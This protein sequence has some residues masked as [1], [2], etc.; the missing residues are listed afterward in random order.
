MQTL[1]QD[2]RYGLR[3]FTRSL[4]FTLV[5]VLSLALGI[6][7]N[8]AIF[9]LADTVLLRYLPVR[10]PEKLVILAR[11]SPRGLRTNFS[12]PIYEDFR[13]KQDVFSGVLARNV[14]P[15]NMEASSGTER[16]S[17]ELVS[18]NY[19][20]VLGVEALLGRA[21]T[22]EDDLRPGA[23]PVAVFS[24]GFWQRRFGGDP[25]VM[26]HTI[27]LNGHPFTVVGVSPPGFAGVEI[28]F[29]PEIRVPMMMQNDLMP[30]WTRMRER[31]TSWLEVMARLKPGLSRAQA[32]AAVGTLYQG[33]L[34]LELQGAGP[35]PPDL[36]HRFLEQRLRLLPGGRG[37]SDV[38]EELSTPL[39]ALMGVVGF[40]LLIAC[41]NVANLLLA[42]AAGRRRE[43]AIRLAVGASRGRLVRQLLT[44]SIL[45][46]CGGGVL[47]LLL[48]SY[49]NTFLLRF[50]PQTDPPVT[51]NLAP[52]WRI[53][54]FTLLVSLLTGVL[55]GLGPGMQATRTDI[56]PALKDEAGALGAGRAR[57][58]LRKA[59]L[60][61][62]VALSLVL[63]IGAGLLVRSLQKLRDLDVG[64]L[65][66]NVLLLSLDPGLSGYNAQRAKAFYEGLLERVR[67]LP[68]VRAAS[69]ASVN[70]LTGGGRRS[71]YEV[72]GYQ[73]RPGEDMALNEN[74]L[75]P[76][77]FETLGIPVLLGRDFRP[78]DDAGS[79]K[80][81]IVN[82][83]MARY[84]FKDENP[85]GKRIGIGNNRRWDIEIIGV[86][87]NAKYRRLREDTWRTVYL[88][89]GQSSEQGLTL[90]LRAIGEPK[91]TAAAVR[92]E[93]QALDS[94]LPVFGVR[95]MA[96]QL[97]SALAPERLV[98]ALSS[99]FGLLALLL[100]AVGLYGVMAYSVARR[101]RE[102][103]IRMALGA[104]RSDVLWM[105]LRETLALTGLGV[106][107]GIP[108][109]F[110]LTRLVSTLLYQVR[111]TDVATTAGATV[112]LAA[113]ALLAGYLPARRAARVDPIV[114]LRYE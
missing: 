44:E 14:I 53:L 96:E 25:S 107:A 20:S 3:Q 12:Y 62:Q 88:P 1:L 21:L 41:A 2:L 29:A 38:R 19:F 51:F 28:G 108:A 75:S 66:E 39:L 10:R 83:Q 37:F 94:S 102:I 98:A 24:Y 8:T 60:A 100:A 79:P 46:A 13:D 26:G 76:G 110:A 84:F 82:E 57:F 74:I 92:Q 7:A 56:S 97:D 101:T 32:E 27:R 61:G 55:F 72:Q 16:V 48:A 85:I 99:L 63:L 105:V 9:T 112:F 86:V 68:G 111:P 103:G 17:G 43:I 45:L 30:G 65:R 81:A 67:T 70:L 114:A 5:A 33:L 77:Y 4:A 50:I 47:G 95:T 18:G 89:L 52:D 91:N 87:K 35:V 11:V 23:H 109:A 59:L 93:V 58:G 80:V 36:R 78:S 40:V 113:V 106:A 90:H 34:E 54:G 49:G 104:E 31:T 42:R 73:P 15:L 6:G 22:R 69:L 64:F 71:S